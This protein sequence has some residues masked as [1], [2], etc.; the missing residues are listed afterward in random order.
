MYD[1]LLMW[2]SERG[3]GTLDSFRE[4]H[5]WLRK[6]RKD[7]TTAGWRI[8]IFNMQVLGH[9][10]VN[11]DKRVW[12]ITP[13]AITTLS[14]TPGI[15]LLSGQRPI[16]LMQ[17][18]EKLSRT[19]DPRFKSI[20]G[21]IELLPPVSQDLG[22]SM[23]RLHVSE[24]ADAKHLCDTLGIRFVEYAGDQLLIRLPRLQE[25]LSERGAL[26]GPGGLS[27]QRIS[28]D[29][30]DIWLDADDGGRP[31]LRGTYRYQKYNTHQYVY[32]IGDSG[33]VTDKR[34]A[35]YAE[36]ART[37]RWVLYFNA[38]GQELYV[39]KRFPLPILHARAAVLRSGMLP[40]PVSTLGKDAKAAFRKSDQQ[41]LMM[42][43]N[44]D[45][46]FAAILA[47]SLY[48]ELQSA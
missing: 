48:Q 6:R 22:P 27:A 4:A 14:G 33:Y 47:E 13:P 39:P 31:P 5:D 34:S 36:L 1:E 3:W 18:L 28:P 21:R 19:I 35:I 8:A 30:D 42:Y 7:V 44:I 43:R 17:I 45:K 9:V 32:W 24:T 29:C 10:E 41:G 16:W 12:S 25:M 2:A 46:R 20:T 23:R 11:W 26:H 38:D 40:Q 37:Q 15:V